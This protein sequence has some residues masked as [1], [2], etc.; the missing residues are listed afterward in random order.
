M[1]EVVL[2]DE[3]HFVYGGERLLSSLPIC[4]I[5]HLMVVAP[6]VIVSTI[7]IAAVT[8]SIIQM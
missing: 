8:Y 4:L 5:H 3:E 1:Q 6:R 7:S 2:S